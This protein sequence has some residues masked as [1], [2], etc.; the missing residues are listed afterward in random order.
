[1]ISNEILGISIVAVMTIFSWLLKK[2]LSEKTKNLATIQDIN[3]ITTIVETIKNDNAKKLEEIKQNNLLTLATKNKHQDLKIKIYSD[4]IEAITKASNTFVM[5]S[6][7]TY[8]KD[9]FISETLDVG[10]KI[11]KIQ[12]VGES[13]TVNSIIKIMTAFNIGAL[14]LVQ[15]RIPLLQKADLIKSL[16]INEYTDHESE[17]LN[18]RIE[19]LEAELL[20]EHIEFSKI[21]IKKQRNVN[22]FLPSFISSIRKELEL[23]PLEFD[24]FEMFISDMDL[25]YDSFANEMTELAKSS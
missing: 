13:E 15:A 12:V 20:E 16:E 4:A 8:D 3:K 9:K 6:D 23:S 1:M 24:Q 17:K 14:D 10:I 19:S 18:Y 25:A 2:Y 11:A 7:L 22:E 5:F 21:C